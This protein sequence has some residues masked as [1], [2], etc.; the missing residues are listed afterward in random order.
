M[1]RAEGQEVPDG[2]FC[3]CALTPVGLHQMP[4]PPAMAAADTDQQHSDAGDHHRP[5]ERLAD[6][7]VIVPSRARKRLAGAVETDKKAQIDEDTRAIPSATC[8][9]I[10]RWQSA[11]GCSATRG[12]AAWRFRPM[13]RQAGRPF[14]Q[15]G[16]SIH[17]A[18]YRRGCFVCA[19][20][21]SARKRAFTRRA[22]AGPGPRI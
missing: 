5:V 2:R 16:S 15:H 6:F 11:A 14:P 12:I 18:G 8:R 13:P 4:G 9:S 21:R 10:R 1:K 22:Q 20:E 17:G 7:P 19:G 3:S